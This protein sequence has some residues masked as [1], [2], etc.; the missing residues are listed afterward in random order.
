MSIALIKVSNTVTSVLP[1]TLYCSLNL[2]T[3][4][5][6]TAMLKRATWQE[7]KGCCNSL[8]R[9][10]EQNT[11]IWVPYRTENCFLTVLETAS[12][13]SRW[14]HVWFLVRPLFL[15]WKCRH[16]TAFSHGLSSVYIC[17]EI[18]LAPLFLLIRTLILLDYGPILTTSL[19]LNYVLKSPFSNAYWVRV[20]YN[21]WIWWG[22]N[23]ALNSS[24]QARTS[25]DL[26]L[27]VEQRMK[28]RMSPTAK[29]WAWK[30]ILPQLSHHGRPQTQGQQPGCRLVRDCETEGTDEPYQDSWPR[31]TTW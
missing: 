10:P 18:P 31:K 4:M 24:L 14:Y 30:P 7:T 17:R 8:S 2:F 11:T 26:R 13:R 5:K 9:L 27:S 20:T 29:E 21:V 1:A 6:Q 19:N 25:E 23:S 3:V 22:H 16:L 12:L 15:D 28:N